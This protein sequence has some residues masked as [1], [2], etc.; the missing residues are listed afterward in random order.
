MSVSLRTR[1]GKRKVCISG[2]MT[3]YAVAE[4]KHKLFANLDKC[5][6]VVIDLSEVAELDSAGVQLLALS[7]REFARLD[8]SWTLV[9][10]SSP[11]LE[12]LH[13]YCLTSELDQQ[14]SQSSQIGT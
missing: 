1:N 10:H 6:E 7:K 8:K 13:K 14:K 3:I 11:V 9:D 5:H 12:V 4:I 2:E